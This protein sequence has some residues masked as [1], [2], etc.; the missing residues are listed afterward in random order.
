MEITYEKKLEVAYSVDVLV[1]GGG[2]AGVSAAVMCAR[3]GRSVLLV[4]QTGTLGGAGTLAMVPELMNFDDGVH[5]LAGGFGREVHDA[6][7]G[8][9]KYKREWH[10]VRAE[11]VKR[12]YDGMVSEA[13]VKL[14]FCTRVTDVVVDGGA[15]R[16]AILS[17]PEGTRAVEAKM[18]VDCTGSGGLCTAAGAA[19]EY[20]DDAGNAMPATLCSLW[21]GV[22]F[23]VK[24]SD[25]A[26]LRQAFGDGV[27][28]QFDTVL[29][30]IMATD[31]EV[32]VGG[33][34]V[35][36][37]FMVDDRSAE[38]LTEAMLSGRRTLVEFERYYR[39]YVKGCE[40]AALLRSA[41]FLGV[42]E[43]R[44][45]KCLFTLT[46]EYF[47]LPDA[48]PDEIGRYS[49][50]IDI[51][52]MTPDEEGMRQFSRD[53]SKRHDIGESYS[54]PYRSLVPQ[55]LNNV[56]VAGRCIGTDH[57]MQ[58]SARVIPCCFITG[59]AAGIAAAVCVESGTP[60]PAADIGEL[61]RRLRAAG[62]YL[63][64]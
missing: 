23:A 44:R 35:G 48:F 19:Y 62:A 21:G 26:K 37:C 16:Y 2:P 30:G 58:A 43:S 45:I 1:A 57:A 12:L 4:E 20:G 56:F 15:A 39:G 59:Q 27:L 24:R 61:R 28:T 6:L 63:A 31:P 42:R 60:A 55:G 36:H 3:Q 32:G 46:E 49:Y 13:G 47:S 29:P 7:F 9:C 40:G 50:P 41:D 54:I 11:R 8:E 14:L 38:S 10:P 18:Y 17:G 52:P 53:V 5:F 34:N 22:D 25:G 33:G 64:D 51:H